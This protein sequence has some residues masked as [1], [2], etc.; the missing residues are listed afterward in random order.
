MT[1]D[2]SLRRGLNRQR[3]GMTLLLVLSCL[4]L[5][6]VLVVGF[7]TMTRTEQQASAAFSDRAEV[8]SLAEIPM[9]LVTAQIRKATEH[10]GVERTWASQP[11]M[12][13]VFGVEGDGSGVRARATALYK[14]YSDDQMVVTH[15]GVTPRSGGLDRDEVAVALSADV[16]D[17]KNWKSKPGLFTDLNA[18]APVVGDG[19]H[20]RWEFPIVDPRATVGGD[21]MPVAGFT[22]QPSGVEGAAR[23]TSRDDLSAR[24]PM[25]VRWIYILEDG[26][27]A[28]PARSDGG[29]VTFDASNRPSE[30]NP[31][32]GRIAFW[33]DDE[34]AKVN[35][36]TASEGIAWEVPRTHS[37]SDRA[38]A[39]RMP[40]RH[41]FSRYPGHPAMTC[42]SPVFQAFGSEFAISPWLEPELLR[43]RLELYHQFSPR[44]AFGGTLGGTVRALEPVVN[45]KKDRLYATVD[46]L[47]F[48]PERRVERASIDARDLA[49]G[50]FFLTTH[51]RAPELNLFNKPRMGLWPISRSS[52]QRNAQDRMMAF[53]N[54]AGVAGGSVRS[55]GWSFYRARNTDIKAGQAGSSQNPYEDLTTGIRNNALV[56]SY[57]AYLTGEKVGDL[58]YM[59][60][61]FGNRTMVEKYGKAKRDQILTEIFDLLRWGVA[62]ENMT[63]TPT[64][65]YLPAHN[66]AVTNPA[67]RGESSAVP[68][69]TFKGGAFQGMNNSVSTQIVRDTKGFGRFPTLTEADLV[70]IA[71]ET[72]GKDENGDGYPDTTKMRAFLVVE[73]FS[74]T[75]GAPAWTATWR[76]RVLFAGQSGS[77]WKVKPQ[78]ASAF[79]PLDFPKPTHA[80]ADANDLFSEIK[81]TWPTSMVNLPVDLLEGGNMT[82]FSGMLTQFKQAYISTN[83]PGSPPPS[84]TGKKSLAGLAS[85]SGDPPRYFPF[86]SEAI[87]VTGKQSFELIGGEL[88]FALFTGWTGTDLPVQKIRMNFPGT[89]L[90]VPVLS[91][92]DH[93]SGYTRLS[94][95]FSMLGTQGE[96]LRDVI[97][98]P[99]DVV[100]SVE[101]KASGVAKGDLRHYAAL[102]DVPTSYFEPSPGYGDISVQQTQGLRDGAWAEGPQPGQISTASTAGSLIEG[103][104]YPAHAVPAVPRGLTAALNARDRPG[105]WDTGVGIVED[106]PMINKPDEANVLLD[107][108]GYFQRGGEFAKEDGTSFA[109]NRQICSAVAFGSLPTGIHPTNP[110]DAEPWQTLLF[111]PNPASRQTG[112]VLE[113]TAEDHRGFEAPR[114]HLLLDLFWMPVVEPYAISESFSTAGKINMNHQ[115]LP[116]SYIERSTGLHAVLRSACVTAIPPSAVNEYK[117]AGNPSTREYRYDVNVEQTLKGFEQRFMQWDVFRSA[118]EICEIFLVPKGRPNAPYEVSWM[119]AYNQMT[120]WWNGDL[121]QPDAM[122]LT[123]DNVREAPYAGLYPRLTT[124]SNTYTVHY[125]VQALK[126]A[127]GTEANLWVEDRDRVAADYRG[128]A[129]LERYMDPNELEVG[130]IGVGSGSFANTWDHHFRMRVVSRRAFV[131]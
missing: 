87:D 28:Y 32:V 41:E 80:G 117:D 49:I 64:Y 118:S 3:Q 48:N 69:I 122:D 63:G 62:A 95:R 108:G 5:V 35:L 34:C 77:A 115:I 83:P 101:A 81:S 13:R 109:P 123:G 60:P 96:D 56:N 4:A 58:R 39:E 131:P 27:H 106:G 121:A 126:K 33:T 105:D 54:N 36:N 42:L 85:N 97:I 43:S 19:T 129:E 47:I 12:I 125:R 82:P 66:D 84:K 6:A 91:A 111:C 74:P 50:R 20:P 130:E 14:L 16:A 124:Q 45:L 98:R 128:S 18:P 37:P 72:S 94:T 2:S 120:Q 25:P 38:M 113:P 75:C 68:T 10:L 73:P 76:Y 51:S 86:Y 7:L 44:V 78:G 31:I 65:R 59:V 90:Q 88:V 116:F 55:D 21:A 46:E 79:I 30:K 119:P 107:D 9:N 112:S 52:S 26:S 1:S 57:L 22:Y 93:S 103:L 102:A 127:R 15:A 67:R 114:D 104:A 8:S 17:L 24:L 11:G 23:A 99:G 71:T 110:N 100:R 29:K 92:S 53:L 89:T 40:V 70:F 61:G